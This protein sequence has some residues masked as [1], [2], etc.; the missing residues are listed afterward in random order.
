MISFFIMIV[1]IWNFYIG[2]S[3]G[4]ILQGFYTFASIV[5]L[6]I[7]SQLYKDLSK[8][9]TLWIPY[10]NA[11]Q[12]TKVSFFTHVNI[13]DLDKVYYAGVAF[14]AIYIV[15]YLIFR[16]IGIFVHFAPINHFDEL[17]I[18]L[19][20]GALSVLVTL[21]FFSLALTVLATVPMTSIQ[22]LLG[23]SIFAKLLINHF[24]I[25]STVLD[26]FWVTNILK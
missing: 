13:F 15:S 5:S 7:A 6:V 25:L 21:I 18:N 4:I 16:L 26:N 10:S 2:Y 9:I 22:N 3:R 8:K 20:S 19:I 17:K 14:T 23:H 24:P 1:L 11:T 12:G